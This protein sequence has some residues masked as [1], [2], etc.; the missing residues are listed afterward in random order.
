MSD[1]AAYRRLAPQGRRPRVLIV[2]DQP[3]NIH[4]LHELLRDAC[5]VSMALDGT[6]AL[7]LCQQQPPDLVLLDVMMPEL[8]GLQVCRRLKADPATA[9]IPVV[10]VTGQ[11]APEDEVAALEAGGADFISKPVQP[12]VVRARVQN[13]LIM[14]LQ[15]DLLREVAL[16]DGLTGVANRRRFDDALAT[17][18]QACL[19]EGKPCG[20]LMIDVDYFKRYNDHYGHQLGDGCLRAVA[21]ALAG[22]V[23]RPHD[24]LARYGGEEFVALLPGSDADGVREVAQRMLQRVAELQ[25]AHDASLVGPCVSISLGGAVAVPQADASAAQLLAQAD[26]QLYLAKQGGRARACVG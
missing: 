8:D 19:R 17:H 10:F 15:S 16:L 26:A 5:E 7:A 25:L 9:D 6:R 23:L 3:I 13:H 12:V 14:K 21:Q 4:A 22:C 2:D 18:W 1:F 24:L 11:D 20:A